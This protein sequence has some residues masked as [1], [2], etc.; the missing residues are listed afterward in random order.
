LCVGPLTHVNE[1]QHMGG[2]N[3]PERANSLG[4]EVAADK[5]V[6]MRLN[7]V[8]PGDG[9]LLERLV[10]SRIDTPVLQNLPNGRGADRN[11]QLLEFAHDP[12]VA[13]SQVLLSQAQDEVGRGHGNAWPTQPLEDQTPRRLAPP[14]AVGFETHDMDHV[15]D[16]MAQDLPEA[17]EFRLLF[18]GGHDAVGVDA[19]AE[20]AELRF[21]ELK[22]R[23][24]ARLEPLCDHGGHGEEHP[25][26]GPSSHVSPENDPSKPSYK[27]APTFL[28]PLDP[29][30]MPP[31]PECGMRPIPYYTNSAEVILK[32]VLKK[33]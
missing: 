2:Q 9:R 3:T 27:T 24:V 5:R 31:K 19:L 8:S 29:G 4:K 33:R 14:S 7:E 6:H 23:V 12:A 18:R 20:Y 26:H 21:Q 15:S 13:P 10:R 17:Q 25:M 1:N 22:P 30:A 16:I 28:N 11:T 32:L